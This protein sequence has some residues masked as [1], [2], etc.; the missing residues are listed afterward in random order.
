MTAR[1]WASFMNCP[2]CN[3]C[4]LCILCSIVIK[5]GL[6]LS[7]VCVLCT[8]SQTLFVLPLGGPGRLYSV[9]VAILFLDIFYTVFV[10]L[11]VCP[12]T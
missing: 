6:C 2:D 5:L 9:N 4:V 3:G 1:C 11:S 12:T 10:C 8:L 7:L